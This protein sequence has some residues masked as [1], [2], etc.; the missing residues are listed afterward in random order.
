MEEHSQSFDICIVCALHEEAKAVL[1]EIVARCTVSFAQAFSSTDSYE[2]HYT[3]IQNKK[4]EPLT[5]LVT[6]LAGSGPVRTSLDLKPLLQ[7]FR[8][9]FAAMTGFCAGYK[10]KVRL[11]DLVV[12]QDAYHYEEGKVL[13]GSD[14]QSQNILE[15][16]TYGTTARVIHYARGFEGWKEPMAELKHSKLRHQELK[17]AEQ[18]KCHIGSMASGMA[19]RGDNPFPRLAGYHNRKTI[20]LD[21]EAAAF[22]LTLQ[23]FPGIHA[24]VI[25]G[26]CDYADMEKNDTYH[27]YAARASAIYLLSFIQEYVTQKT[28]PKGDPFF[29]SSTSQHQ[30]IDSIEPE[31]RKYQNLESRGYFL[32]REGD[33]N[34]VLE[35]LARYLITTIEGI[36]GV[37]KT[38]L[39][40]EVAYYC[41][42]DPGR[43]LQRPFDAVVWV[44]AR[45]QSGGEEWLNEVMD[46]IALVLDYPAF[47]VS[48]NKLFKIRQ[49]LQN[50]R[51]LVVVDNFETIENPNRLL[52]W[53]RQIPE[54]SKVLITSRLRQLR[55][56]LDKPWVAHLRGLSEDEALQLIHNEV[57]RLELAK[58]RVDDEGDL[59]DLIRITAGNPQAI[60]MALG[61]LETTVDVT[62]KMIIRDLQMAGKSGEELFDHLYQKE[63]EVLKSSPDAQHLLFAI[64]FFEDPANEKALKAAAGMSES[65]FSQSAHQLEIMSLLENTEQ[66]NGNLLRYSIHPLTRAFVGRRLSEVSQW[67]QEAR[68]R[69]VQWYL[70][71]TKKNGGLDWIIRT[72]QYDAIERE[73]GNLLAVLKWCVA[74]KRYDNLKAFWSKD[75]LRSFTD[76]N[77]HWSERL[78]YF[79]WIGS[80][81]REREDWLTCIDVM[82]AKSWTLISMGQPERLQEADKI[83]AQAHELCDRVSAD[84]ATVL[85]YHLANDMTMRELRLHTKNAEVVRCLKEQEDLLKSIK[86]EQM[87]RRFLGYFLY[88]QGAAYQIE[89]QYEKAKDSFQQCLR[90]SEDVGWERGTMYAK[91]F[92]AEIAIKQGKL[93][94]ARSLLEESRQLVQNTKDKRHIAYY[95]RAFAY[96]EQ[97]QNNPQAAHHWAMDALDD[98]QYLDM[99]PEVEKMRKFDG[100]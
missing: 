48:P 59:R 60:V 95:K 39:A 100:D 66:S 86:D 12:A 33:K 36:G 77:G 17:D 16:K 5:V 35:G 49:L 98:F 45:E 41:L 67:Q 69:W 81:A 23:G 42:H 99:E 89:E 74:H 65:S 22:Y 73:W 92:L 43:L 97:A 13:V 88:N 93:D 32:G 70:D 40:L 25:K 20:A 46:R 83:L 94:K 2:Y 80:E 15:M 19:V 84:N 50:C 28:M 91:I 64:T 75:R 96:L 68:E 90:I 52:T 1:D 4:G 11:G 7:E 14:G 30:Q 76:R 87:Y 79:D 62:L 24:L 38:S 54:P 51:T 47:A 71:F 72:P 27:D 61:Y 9:R 26:V 56:P 3:T 31:P 57:K 8:P 21:M 44:S 82:E 18:P 55:G 85:R 37:G 34:R 78:T 53:L 29:L 58:S 63:W 10:E 6:W